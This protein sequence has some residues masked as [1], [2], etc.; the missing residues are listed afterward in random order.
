MS[1][2]K[3]IAFDVDGTLLNSQKKISPATAAAIREAAHKGKE[4]ALSTGRSLAE[5]EEFFQVIPEFRYLIL[6]SGAVV[7]DRKKEEIIF[8]KPI[9]KEAADLLLDIS[10]EQ[11]IMQQMFEVYQPFMPAEKMSRLEDYE[12]GIYQ[13]LFEKTMKPVEDVR[14]Y[15]EKNQPELMKFNFYHRTP[16]ARE[17]TRER[18]LKTG[19]PLEVV[20]SETT[21][22]ECNAMGISK[23]L[24]LRML[25]EKTGI[26]PEE[27]IAV[28]DADND[29]EIL[30]AAGLAIAMGNAREHVKEICDVIVADNDHDGCKEAVEI[31]LGGLL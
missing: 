31:L 2:Y 3:L 26:K 1:E 6:S 7:Y 28:G 9:P 20:Y 27:T 14:A 17:V 8:S 10:E 15:Y 25:C 29:V 13:K 21:S 11:D 19:L 22:I 24:G 16:A 30:K 4:V 23:G 5:C 12:M 18:I